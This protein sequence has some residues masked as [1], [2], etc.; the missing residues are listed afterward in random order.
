MPGGELRELQR[1]LAGALRR[2]APIGDDPA[3]TAATAAHVAGNDRLTP[4][5]QADIYRGQFW[6]RH[7]DALADDHPGLRAIVGDDVFDAL[8]HAYLE[9]HPPRTPS[10]RELGA[11]LVGFARSWGGFPP[12]LR[13]VA[14]EMVAYEHLFVDLFDGAEPPP[15]DP[16]KLQGLPDDA[17][18]R[19]RIVLSPLLARVRLE[20]PLHLYRLAV[21]EAGHDDEAPPLPEPRAVSLAL[22]RRELVIRYEELEPEALALLDALAAGEPLAPACERVAATLPADAA[23]ALGAKVGPWFQA[24]TANRWIVDV[25]LR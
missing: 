8:V 7:F 2:E 1:F 17:W 12:P 24:W 10:L 14:V 4:A 6:I 25:D 23:E 9:A 22:Y 11:D 21:V 19:A 20:R 16:A 18:D 3:V 5:E 13:D 15:L